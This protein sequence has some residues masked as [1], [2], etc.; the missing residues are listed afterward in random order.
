[1]TVSQWIANGTPA[2]PAALL[3][4]IRAVLGAAGDS[5]ARHTA[6]ACVDAAVGL[7]RDIVRQGRFARDGA[8]DLLAADALVT[9]AF[10]YAARNGSLAELTS[11]CRRAQRVMAEIPLAHA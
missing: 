1:M 2:P 10:E 4:R 6:D 7:L 5:D 8:L 9:Y 11:T 3:D